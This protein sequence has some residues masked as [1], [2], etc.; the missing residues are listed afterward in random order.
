MLSRLYFRPFLK[1]FESRHKRTVEDKEA[2]ERLM[3]QANAKLD[4]YRRLLADER[5]AAKKA[6][7]L[8]LAEAR[9]QESELLGHAREEAKIITQNAADSVNRQ[10]ELLKKQLEA[11]VEVIAQNISDKLL[12]RKE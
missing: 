6:Y 1:L 9:K 5:L 8:A 12:L 2:A 11:D 3:S 4:E 10:R 7:D